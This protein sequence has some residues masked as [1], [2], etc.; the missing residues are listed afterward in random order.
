MDGD[1]A[2]VHSSRITVDP[3]TG[4]FNGSLKG[5]FTLRKNKGKVLNGK[6]T[7]NISGF[8]IGF[9]PSPPFPPFTPI[10]RVLD[11]GKWEMDGKIDA[12]GTFAITLDGIVGLPASQ[13]GLQGGGT[14]QGMAEKD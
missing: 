3:L 10:H 7:A 6:M 12:K 9:A 8:I 4:S 11:N 5:T 1:F 13:G 2:T 14:M